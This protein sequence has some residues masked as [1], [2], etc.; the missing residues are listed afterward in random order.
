MTIDLLVD[1]FARADLVSR[2]GTRWQGTSDRVM[3]GLSRETLALETQ[4]GRRWLRLT[5]PVRLENEG[6]FL[7]AGLD[8]VP[9]GGPRDL[10]AFAGLRLLVRGNGE[11]YGCHLRTTD[12]RRPWQSYRSSFLAVPEPAEIDLPLSGFRPHRVEAPLDRAKLRRVALVAIGRA[13]EAD[14]AVAE[15]AFY[16]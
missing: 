13:F 1:D 11:R 15:V 2:L 5:G 8:L 12:C 16:R 7:Q 10:L 3:G 6:G 9:G 14:L 4:G